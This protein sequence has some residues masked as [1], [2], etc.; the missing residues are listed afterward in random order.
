MHG[1]A[2]AAAAAAN[3]HLNNA[4]LG[5]HDVTTHLAALAHSA[6]FPFTTGRSQSGTSWRC[7]AWRTRARRRRCGGRRRHTGTPTWRRTMRSRRAARKRRRAPT[8]CGR[9]C[10]STPSSPPMMPSGENKTPPFVAV[11]IGF[12][13]HV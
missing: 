10:S 12:G 2:A 5:S 1:G 13:I 4:F 11:Q 8:R 6:I 9:S 3:L 7:A